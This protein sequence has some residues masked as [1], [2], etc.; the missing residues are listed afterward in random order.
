MLDIMCHI[1]TLEFIKEATKEG[2]GPGNTSEPQNGYG[3]M[4][5]RLESNAKPSVWLKDY[6]C[7]NIS[8]IDLHLYSYI[9]NRYLLQ[10]D[11]I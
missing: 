10:F 7:A 2:P 8:H 1:D 6:D 5:E 4:K 9:V 11:Q 3:T